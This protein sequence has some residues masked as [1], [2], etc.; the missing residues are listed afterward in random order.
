MRRRAR[1][2]VFVLAL[3]VLAVVPTWIVM[4]VGRLSGTPRVQDGWAATV[5]PESDGARPA[6]RE[7]WSVSFRK[8]PPGAASVATPAPGA[9]ALSRVLGTIGV[10]DPRLLAL[11]ALFL[12][13][14]L[15]ARAGPRETALDRVAASVALP[16]A[17]V[18]VVFGSGNLVMLALV[19]GAAFVVARFAHVT[20]E[21]AIARAAVVIVAI[22]VAARLVAGAS[23]LPPLGPGLGLSNLR[24]YMGALPDSSGLALPA[25]VVVSAIVALVLVRRASLDGPQLLGVGAAVLMIALWLAPSAAPDDVVVPIA[26]LAI[27]ITHQGHETFDTAGS[28]L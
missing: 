3:V 22:V 12:V 2:V 7:A 28:A 26:L 21:S 16:P 24:L 4:T 14:V 8:D 1:S 25:L 5:W 6:L 18:G 27:A 15:I 11:V 13:A 10:R 23:T 17:I 19:L 9:R 20:P